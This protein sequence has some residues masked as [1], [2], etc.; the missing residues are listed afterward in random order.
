MRQN[1]RVFPS[2]H[3]L[4]WQVT[5]HRDHCLQERCA[6]HVKLCWDWLWYL[7]RP[8]SLGRLHT[9]ST[10]DP[11]TPLNFYGGFPN[12]CRP[13]AASSTV[14][15]AAPRAQAHNGSVPIDALDLTYSAEEWVPELVDEDAH[16]GQRPRGRNLRGTARPRE[17]D[18][19]R[20]GTAGDTT[21]SRRTRSTS[22]PRSRRSRGTLRAPRLRS[23]QPTRPHW[24]GTA[25]RRRREAGADLDNREITDRCTNRP[26]QCCPNGEEQ[27]QCFFGRVSRAYELEGRSMAL[28]IG[29]S[30]N[31]PCFQE[32]IR[33]W[34]ACQCERSLDIYA[35][36]AVY[37]RNTKAMMVASEFEVNQVC[38][39]SFVGFQK[40]TVLQNIELNKIL[41]EHCNKQRSLYE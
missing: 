34:S 14:P 8:A 35:C 6:E 33:G 1:R 30:A 13:T 4:T 38:I 18:E 16:D 21:R 17:Y 25:R 40:L 5:L 11:S 12:K 2:R 22:T 39:M 23:G 36:Y 15:A 27:R 20:D 7:Q 31:F 29:P 28:A 10:S 9:A 3:H 24:Q 32:V 19:C 41:E 26:Q 37:W